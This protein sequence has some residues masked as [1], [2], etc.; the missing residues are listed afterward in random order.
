VL[1]K[2]AKLN[3]RWWAKPEC[4]NQSPLTSILQTCSEDFNML[5][6]KIKDLPIKLRKLG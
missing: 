1:P 5:A 2:W 6:L 4:Q 3:C